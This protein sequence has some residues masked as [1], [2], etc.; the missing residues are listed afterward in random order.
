MR[1][2]NRCRRCELP[3][4]WAMAKVQYGRMIKRG[5]TPDEAKTLSPCCSKCTT[6]VLQERAGNIPATV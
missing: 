5:L 2:I 1:T 6:I 3:L 4:T